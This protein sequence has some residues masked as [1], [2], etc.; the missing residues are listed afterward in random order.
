MTVLG[1]SR[2]IKLLQERKCLRAANGRLIYKENYSVVNRLCTHCELSFEVYY[3]QC[4]QIWF[5]S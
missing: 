5:K 4:K 2:Y 3:T 1:L